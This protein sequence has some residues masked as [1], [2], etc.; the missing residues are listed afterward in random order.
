MLMRGKS[1]EYC[2]T[3]YPEHAAQLKPWLDAVIDV[4]ENGRS[5]TV[6]Q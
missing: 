1:P 5:G 3:Q 2:Y 4:R 6:R